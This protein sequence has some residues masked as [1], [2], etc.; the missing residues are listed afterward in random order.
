MHPEFNTSSTHLEQLLHVL[1]NMMI[2]VSHLNQSLLNYLSGTAPHVQKPDSKIWPKSFGL[3]TEDVL[4]GLDYFDNVASYHGW[5][6]DRKAM[7][8]RTQQAE[9]MKGDWGMLKSLLI[10]NFAHQNISQSTLQQLHALKQHQLEPVAQFAVKMNQ[11]LLC[12]D[13]SM[14]EEMKL[15]YLWPRPRHDIS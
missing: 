9:D 7:E 15:F 11:L 14:S 1:S 2:Q 6:D 10:Q 5:S 12:A 3:L 8:A 4:T 13:P